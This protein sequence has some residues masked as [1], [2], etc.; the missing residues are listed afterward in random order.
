MKFLLF[1]ASQVGLSYLKYAHDIYIKL[2]LNKVTNYMKILKHLYAKMFGAGS[3]E[4]TPSE[5]C[6]LFKHEA[7]SLDTQS[8]P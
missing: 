2:K 6:L 1:W 7:V 5:K 3:E 4:V 8:L